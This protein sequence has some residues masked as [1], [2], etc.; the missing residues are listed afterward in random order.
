MKYREGEKILKKKM[1][2]RGKRV[3][4]GLFWW[5]KKM[6]RKMSR[7]MSKVGVIVSPSI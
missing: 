7:K 2:M 4:M 3:K 6:G 5:K 1:M